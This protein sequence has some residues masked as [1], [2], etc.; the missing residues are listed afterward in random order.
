[1]SASHNPE[2]FGGNRTNILKRISSI[3]I[4][5]NSLA[6][7]LANGSKRLS[8]VT[9]EGQPKFRNQTNAFSSAK[10]NFVP[11]VHHFE[12]ERSPNRTNVDSSLGRLH[13]L[14]SRE[15]QDAPIC[16]VKISRLW[17]THGLLL[18]RDRMGARLPAKRGPA[19]GR[20][21]VAT[22]CDQGATCLLR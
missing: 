3:Y 4:G 22:T 12:N 16:D 17:A 1:M 8:N 18:G 7:R 19:Y 14:A 2:A 15:P 10:K 5:K 13:G 21:C 9:R 6:G 20:T 11:C